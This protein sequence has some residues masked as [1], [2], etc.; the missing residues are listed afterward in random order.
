MSKK[1]APKPGEQKLTEKDRVVLVSSQGLTLSFIGALQIAIKCFCS[2]EKY[3]EG[4]IS[5]LGMLTSVLLR[6]IDWPLLKTMCNGLFVKNKKIPRN[7]QG[8]FHNSANDR[9][10]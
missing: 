1:I 9:E 4:F 2:E 7:G 3:T 10:R 6:T 8:I 5:H